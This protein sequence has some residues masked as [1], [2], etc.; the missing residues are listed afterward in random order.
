[1]DAGDVGQLPRSTQGRE[2]WS[3]ELQRQ[4]EDI[5]HKSHL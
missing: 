1:M 5:Y 2:E 4:M 3:A